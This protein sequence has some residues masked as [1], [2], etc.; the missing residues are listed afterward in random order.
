MLSQA[1]G[2]FVVLAQLPKM[3]FNLSTYPV[4]ISAKQLYYLQR[5]CCLPEQD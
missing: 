3:Q 2:T 1:L 5:L 4:V